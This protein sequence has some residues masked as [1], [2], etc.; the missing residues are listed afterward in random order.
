MIE[1]RGVSKQFGSFFAN[2][3]L[4]FRIAPGSIHGLVGENGA[5]KS[6]AMKLL[7]GLYPATDGQIFIQGKETKIKSPIHAMKLGIGMVHQHFMLATSETVLDNIVLGHE[8]GYAFQQILNRKE[9]RRQ[10]TEISNR[11]GLKFSKWDAFVSDLSVGEQ[12][13]VEIIKLLFQKSDVLIL[14]EPTAVLTPQ[15][16]IE[17]FQN[18]KRLKDEG[19]TIVLISHKLKEVLAYTDEITVLRRG[20]TVGTVQTSAVTEDQLAEMMVGRKVSFHYSGERRIAAG[21]NRPQ[22]PVLEIKNLT[23]RSPSTALKNSNKNLLSQIS[24]QLRPG[25]ILGI[26]GVQGNG[27]TELLKYLAHPENFASVSEG[28][29]R[30]QGLH[31]DGLDPQ[32]LRR[33]G[34]GLVPEDRH[35]EGLLLNQDMTENFLLGQQQDP[36]YVDFGL[37]AGVLSGTI[38]RTQ[39]RKQL[40]QKIKDFDIR[41]TTSQTLTGSMSGGNQQKLLL[42]RSLD[43]DPSILLIAHPTRGVDVGAIELI[44]DVIMKERN[45]GR[46]IVLFSS[47]L[48]ELFDLS[49]RLLVFYDGKIAAEFARSQFDPWVVGRVMGGGT[50]A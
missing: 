23:L 45:R 47:E 9:A 15:E 46:S 20:E 41:P 19:K 28:E 29:Y 12:Q 14:D 21:M 4:N 25:E 18:L 49:D 37:T 50:V 17:L 24:F 10:L 7:F 3:N 26:G 34:V 44:H 48:D 32:G 13:Q 22:K 35:A 5:G 40:D 11:Y 16:V 30:I 31:A 6:T 36:R 42:A 1:F 2:R 8:V 27:Q 33:K 43:A 39:V 38:N